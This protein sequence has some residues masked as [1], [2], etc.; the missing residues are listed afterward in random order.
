MSTINLDETPG[1]KVGGVELNGLNLI[2]ESERKGRPSSLFWPWFAANVSVLGVAY[3]SFILGF[4]ISFWQATLVGVIGIVLSFLFCGFISLAGKRGSAPTLTL[5]RA[6][7]GVHGNRLPSF[8]SWLI[9]VGWETVLASLAVLAISTVFQELGFG[10]GMTTKIVTLVV[11]IL[12]VVGGG[13]YGFDVIMRM[14]TVITIVTAVLTA[15]Y[16][17]LVWGH[18]DF[19]A[20]AAVPNGSVTHLVGAFVFTMTGFG[21]GWVQAA[22][23]YSRYLPRRSSSGGVVGWTMFGSSLAPVILVVF[24]LLLAAS[25]VKLNKAIAGDPIGALTTILPTWF[26]IP[27]AVVAILGLVGGAVLDIYSSGIALMSTG[28]KIPRPV[29]AAID[30]VIMV[31]GTIYIVF[32]AGSFIGPFEGFLITLG[33]PIACWCGIFLADL[34]LRRKNYHDV[35][36]FTPRGRYGYASLPALVTLIVGT[37]VGWGLIVNPGMPGMDWLGYLLGPLG[38]V[39]GD[40]AFANLGVLAALVIGYFGVLLF[41]R[42]RVRRQEAVSD[43]ATTTPDF[44]PTM[45]A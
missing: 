42:R 29:A 18:I 4:G 38:G 19:G 44:Q 31:I 13:V 3:G 14:Q 10:G 35:D 26:L 27:F 32:F 16:I 21:L 6:S 5:S 39:K 30:G 36:L 20:V 22:A 23:D 40:W 28:L 8:I 41:G 7:F 17:V 15:M 45:D 34:T 24:G 2:D 25:S 37:G 33:T 11:V 43:D 9:T 12:L 1:G